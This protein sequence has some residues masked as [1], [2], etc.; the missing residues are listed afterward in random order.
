MA[1]IIAM[2][3][4]N[5]P[6]VLALIALCCIMVWRHKPRGRDF[7]LEHMLQSIRFTALGDTLTFLLVSTATE[8]SLR[9]SQTLEPSVSHCFKL[10][11]QRGPGGGPQPVARHRGS[12]RAAGRVLV[13]GAL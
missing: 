3:A 4:A 10:C 7:G 6:C 1:L 5:A 13:R 9:P 11:R 2:R 8:D 12:G